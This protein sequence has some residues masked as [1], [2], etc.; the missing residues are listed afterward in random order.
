M[1]GL[2]VL[3]ALIT[4]AASICIVLCATYKEKEKKSSKV[5]NECTRLHPLAKDSRPPFAPPKPEPKVHIKA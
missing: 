2:C 3:M 5:L 1:T 4:I